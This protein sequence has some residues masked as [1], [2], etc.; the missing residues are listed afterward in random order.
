MGAKRPKSL[1]FINIEFYIYTVLQA[2]IL[3]KVYFF[4][5]LNDSSPQIQGVSEKVCL[6]FL[7]Y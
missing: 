6:G 1:D 7:A 4:V 3:R 2:S 5:A